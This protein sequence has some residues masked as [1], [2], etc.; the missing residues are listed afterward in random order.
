MII[1]NFSRKKKN[2]T[3]IQLKDRMLLGI[4]TIKSKLFKK[5]TSL[6]SEW[7]ITRMCRKIYDFS[8]KIFLKEIIVS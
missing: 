4:N 3:K 6:L 2:E 8:K 1:E 5:C 7:I